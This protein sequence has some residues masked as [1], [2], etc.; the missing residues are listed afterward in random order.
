V[1]ETFW[2][3]RLSVFADVALHRV[4]TALYRAFR[5]LGLRGV[6]DLR[7]VRAPTA[8][9]LDPGDV[10]R[11]L[12]RRAAAAGVAGETMTRKKRGL[13]VVGSPSACALSVKLVKCKRVRMGCVMGCVWGVPPTQPPLFPGLRLRRSAG[14]LPVVIRLLL[15]VLASARR[16]VA[17]P[18]S[19]LLDLARFSAYSCDFRIFL[20]RHQR[21]CA[22]ASP[23]SKN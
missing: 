7:P 13:T 20:Q 14:D 21:I 17:V 12:R 11:I 9:R 22:H 4:D 15:H 19:S 2:D 16:T 3:Q 18:P 1:S 8:N 5:L 6:P 23:S 10:A